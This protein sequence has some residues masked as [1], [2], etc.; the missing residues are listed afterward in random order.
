MGNRYLNMDPTEWLLEDSEPSINYLARKEILNENT[1]NFY[2]R[3]FESEEVKKLLKND[4]DIIGSTKHF[5]LFYKGT[6]WNFAEAVERGLDKR[7]EAINKT[8]DFLKNTCQT[9]TGG[10]SLNWNP[11]EAVACRT[12]DMVRF[13]L[14]AGFS[15]E[16]IRMGIRWIASKQRHD[17]GWL[18]CPIS[19]ICDQIKLVLFNRPGGGLAREQNQQVSSC[20]YAT[21]ACSLA[22]IEYKKIAGLNDF[23]DHIKNAAGYFLDRSFF[24]SDN[25]LEIKPEKGWG[26]KRDFRLIGYPVMSQYDVLYGLLFI[27]K[28]GYFNDHRTGEAFNIILSKQNPDGTWNLETARTGM[29]FGNTGTKHIGR[30][31]KWVTLNVMRLLKYVNA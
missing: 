3:L 25:G 9:D 11:K 4:Q 23:D 27:A 12:G 1:D 6:M 10:F 26:R 30:K 29:L 16:K 21:I 17:G 8:A 5:D 15:D 28:A 24:L 18:H 19:G 31:N 22:L 20:L 7:T 14:R 2:D 13:L